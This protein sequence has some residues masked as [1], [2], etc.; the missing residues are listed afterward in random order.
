MVTDT[1]ISFDFDG[2]YGQST[3]GTAFVRSNAG[4]EGAGIDT[5]LERF[6]LSNIDEM[7]EAI[8]EAPIAIP[9]I[10][11]NLGNILILYLSCRFTCFFD[12]AVRTVKVQIFGIQFV[13]LQ[14]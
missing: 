13:F 3:F 10:L 11:T 8:L 2:T 1:E 6:P 12:V 7:R 5:V 9:Y 14:R 4:D